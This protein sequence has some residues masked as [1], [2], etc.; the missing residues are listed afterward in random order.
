MPGAVRDEPGLTDLPANGG[1]P[2]PAPSPGTIRRHAAESERKRVQI[3]LKLSR[4]EADD[5]D[6]A[7]ELFG[8]RRTTLARLLVV[9]GA[10]EILARARDSAT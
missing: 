1:L 9:R 2:D 10:R 8:V 6:E 5:L 4:L 7:A 3:G